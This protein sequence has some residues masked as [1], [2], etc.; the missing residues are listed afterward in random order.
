MDE[1]TLISGTSDNGSIDEAIQDAIK[2]M[3]AFAGQNGA[4]RMVSGTLTCLTVESGGFA[5]VNKVTAQFNV[6]L[7]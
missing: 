1:T 2:K 6:H 7:R 5:P 4:D 3:N